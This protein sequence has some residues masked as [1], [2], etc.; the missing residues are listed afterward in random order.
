MAIVMKIYLDVADRPP[1]KWC[2]H[3][4]WATGHDS[5]FGLL[6]NF[7]FLNALS[8]RE[9]A[10]LV[11][12]RQRGARTPLLRALQIDLR[13]SRQFDVAMIAALVQTDQATVRRGFLDQYLVD[14]HESEQ[15]L[16]W[17][18]QCMAYGLHLPSSQMRVVTRCPIHNLC[19]RRE[20]QTC[21]NSI[22]YKLCASLF[23]KP[24][25]CPHCGADMGP[26][27]RLIRA[28]LHPLRTDEVT[29]IELMNRYARDC[30]RLPKRAL[31][32]P[33]STAQP[34]SLHLPGT[35]ADE[36]P[37]YLAFVGQVVQAM[38][39]REG[40][41]PLPLSHLTVVRCGCG[42]E[43][44]NEI[45]R[46]GTEDPGLTS[47]EQ[48]QVVLTVYRAIRRN[49]WEHLGHHRRCARTACQHLW[50]DMRGERTVRFC[51]EAAAFIRWRMLWEGCGAP[52]YLQ[53][54]RQMIYFGLLGWL[55]AR[56][57]PYPDEWKQARKVWMLSHVFASVCASSFEVIDRSVRDGDHLCWGDDPATPFIATHWALA[58]E[59]AGYPV[60]TLFL[61]SR[62]ERRTAPTSWASIRTH[63]AWHTERLS[64]VT[65]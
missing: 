37:A 65:R 32:V 30:A 62:Q 49:L 28:G 53:C 24:F 34:S 25:C 27:I 44:D 6:M 60:P 16:K 35:E 9:L 33:Q 18:E 64:H 20:C 1:R 52:R 23:D 46:R 57:A 31:P 36:M 43:P 5:A 29:R 2:W 22:A 7:S 63:R 54:R 42:T 58:D 8:G 55:Q 11:V 15:C 45:F 19:L 4:N 17:C 21:G 41:I 59:R 47:D 3:P 56:P 48:Y 40:Q 12:T 38:K 26:R 13:D 61:P 10:A 50:W 39:A 51:S 14:D